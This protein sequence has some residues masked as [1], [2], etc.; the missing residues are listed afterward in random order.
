MMDAWPFM[1]GSVARLCLVVWYHSLICVIVFLT[2]FN[3]FEALT[4]FNVTL[5]FASSKHENHDNAK[6][7]IRRFVFITRV[8]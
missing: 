8:L 6:F 3:F 4:N 5:Y 2:F 1:N 7:V